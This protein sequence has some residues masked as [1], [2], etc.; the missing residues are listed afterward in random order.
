M[1]IEK[2]MIER[3]QPDVELVSAYL[4]ALKQQFPDVPSSQLFDAAVKLA[5][6]RR[7]ED[8]LLQLDGIVLEMST[9]L[10]A[11]MEELA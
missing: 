7:L 9:N 10:L 8:A 5:G 6:D 4:E 1:T 2:R 3:I 11:L